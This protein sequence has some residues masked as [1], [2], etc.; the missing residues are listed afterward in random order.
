[1]A[2]IQIAPVFFF[3]FEENI[4]FSSNISNFEEEKNKRKEL[5]SPEHRRENNKTRFHTLLMVGNSD[6]LT[7]RGSVRRKV[8]GAKG[9]SENKCVIGK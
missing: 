3:L 4:V 6:R 2:H 5:C 8:N 9:W 1:M 7:F